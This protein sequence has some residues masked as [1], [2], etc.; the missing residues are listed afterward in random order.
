MNHFLT[1]PE[2]RNHKRLDVILDADLVIDGQK[3]N[4]TT[5]NI[6]CGGLFLP[7]KNLNL[8]NKSNIEVVLN[9]PDS[10]KPVKVIG[11]V[12]RVDAIDQTNGVAI[13]FSGLYDDNIL[14][15]DRFIKS[16]LN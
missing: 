8:A 6:S 12:S 7:I 14:A 5:S 10:E 2:K 16:H 4:A 13:K 9:I 1:K 11:E 15:I 3:V